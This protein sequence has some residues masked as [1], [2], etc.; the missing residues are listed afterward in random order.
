MIDQSTKLA[1]QELIAI[2]SERTEIDKIL[3]SRV[4]DLQKS[5]E[6]A[7]NLIKIQQE[8]ITHLQCSLTTVNIV[9]VKNKLTSV[10]EIQKENKK[11]KKTL[12]NK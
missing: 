4:Q 8:E 5:L 6:A 7:I 1:I 12:F 11:I 3:S 10:D 9:L 2:N